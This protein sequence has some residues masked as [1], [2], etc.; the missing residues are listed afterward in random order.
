MSTID[1]GG[2]AF[3]IPMLPGEVWDHAKFGNPNGLS[4]RAYFAGCVNPV[5]YD[6]IE[7]FRQNHRRIPTINELA[8]FI[9]EIRMVEAD[10]IITKLNKTNP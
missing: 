1:N 8:A 5:A 2:P 6:P 3:P 10:A 7:T 4:V 9:A